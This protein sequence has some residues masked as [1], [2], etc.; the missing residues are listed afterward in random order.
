MTSTEPRPGVITEPAP[1]PAGHGAAVET[2]AHHVPG[3]P[4]AAWT[5]AGSRR[6]TWVS[7]AVLIGVLA[8]Q[9]ALSL[10]QDNTAFQDEARYLNSGHVLL[11]HLLHG[12]PVPAD[13][14][15]SPLSGAPALSP[16]LA[17]L[18]D[19]WFGLTGARLLCLLFMLGATT[20]LY[21]LTRR[22][23]NERAALAAAA[24]FAVTQSTVVLG[25]VATDDSAA[26]FLLALATW[27][28]VRT[29]RERPALVLLAAPVA[30]LAVGVAY[31]SVLYLP[32]LV[33]LAALVARPHR[34]G[35]SVVRAVLLALG[36]AGPLVAGLCFTDALD[37]VRDIFTARSP[38]TDG[39]LDLLERSAWW[40]GPLFLTACGGAVAY[41]VRGRMNEAPRTRRLAGPGRA[42]RVL[43]GLL[44]CGTALLA[45][46]FQTHLASSVALHEHLG[47]GLL[48]AA[49]MAGV[50]LTRLVGAHFR[51]PQLACALWVVA[52]CLGISQSAERFASSPDS[53]R[54]NAVLRQ[55][56]TPAMGRYL[57]SQRD[58]VAYHLRDRT[59][60]TRWTSLHGIRYRDP[61]GTVRRGAD[62]YRKALADGWFDLV[63]LDGRTPMDR[64]VAGALRDNAHYRLLGR[65]PY[66]GARGAGDYR[67]WVK[68]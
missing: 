21:A 9:A 12:T 22:L 4:E 29:A 47:F 66:E 60:Q 51:R 23:F 45:P 52:L 13:L 11:A 49:P 56:V 46:M 16:V 36:V 32:T 15:G 20:L 6:R 50:G 59:D 17:A 2:V 40:G 57:A 41:A 55:H 18:A 28:V 5:A 30:A 8:V 44:L 35:A 24:L 48:F 54:L 53:N 68:R 62:G 10:R 7:R 63:V 61:G 43:L 1:R 38:G 42:R 3:T 37:G 31:V 14:A 65:I 64:V 27:I 39:A 33:L 58:V 34:G 25:H 26:M 19:T 67:I